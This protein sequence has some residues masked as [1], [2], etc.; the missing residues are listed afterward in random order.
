MPVGIHVHLCILRLAV[1]SSLVP[2]HVIHFLP[3]TVPVIM[4]AINR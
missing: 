2:A 3:V 1:F 4:R